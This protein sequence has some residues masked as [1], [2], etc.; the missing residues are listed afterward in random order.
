M[1]KDLHREQDSLMVPASV[2]DAMKDITGGALKV[3]IYLCSRYQGRPFAASIRTIKD[4][5]CIG[6][7]CTI[8]SLNT[9]VRL[10]LITR[11]RVGSAKPVRHCPAPTSGDRCVSSERFTA[12]K[13][14]IGSVW[15]ET[16]RALSRLIHVPSRLRWLR[17][18]A[19]SFDTAFVASVFSFVCASLTGSP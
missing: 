10:Q 12:S 14:R 7:R 15:S 13:P 4:A 8:S 1:S 6:A 2:L 11:V 17:T 3:L 16:P 5:T 9:L 19:H 18:P